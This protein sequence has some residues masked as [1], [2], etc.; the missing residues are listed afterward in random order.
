LGV[1]QNDEA[2]VFFASRLSR[3]AFEEW[4]SRLLESALDTGQFGGHLHD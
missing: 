1:R 2:R 3:K 4:V